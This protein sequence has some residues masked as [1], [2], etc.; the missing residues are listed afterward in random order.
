[1]AAAAAALLLAALMTDAG[2]EEVAGL[3]AAMETNE[4]VAELETESPA[5]IALDCTIIEGCELRVAAAIAAGV[6]A[7]SGEDATLATTW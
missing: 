6:L 3:V 5:A 2:V 7:T 4:G 1:M